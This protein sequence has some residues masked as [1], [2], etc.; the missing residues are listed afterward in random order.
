[1]DETN[2]AK[3]G[4]VLKPIFIAI[5][6]KIQLLPRIAILIVTTFAGL[7]VVSLAFPAVTEA[8]T[9]AQSCTSTYEINEVVFGEGGAQGYGDGTC[10]TGSTLY[11]ADETVGDTGVGNTAGTAYQAYGGFNTYR[12]P[13]LTFIVNSGGGSLGTLTAGTTTTTTTTFS[14]KTYLASGY[15]VTTDSNA[16]SAGIHTLTN[17]STATASNSSAEQFGMN[18]VANTTGCGAPANFGS[19][20]VQVPN[21]S[22]S[23]GTAA[24][25]YNTCG[26]FQYNNGDTIAQSTQSSGETDYTISYIFNITNV[27]PA[28]FYTFNQVLVATS[29]F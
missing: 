6:R 19:N 21:S 22:F 25:G 9:N 3:K 2:M 28:G 15:I 10:Y 12:T 11:C 1:V 20:P 8:C 4:N 16:P 5:G 18:L 17:L 7:G 27:T 13:S 14:V 24:T 29:T 23:F 26:L